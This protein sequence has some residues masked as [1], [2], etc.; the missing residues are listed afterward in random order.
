MNNETEKLELM[1]NMK[2]DQESICKL[3]EE[4]ESTA[5]RIIEAR[6]KNEPFHDGSP[7]ESD[8]M[9]PYCFEKVRVS[10]TIDRGYLN[11]NG[12]VEDYIDSVRDLFVECV[13]CGAEFNTDYIDF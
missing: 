2:V 7:F 13:E 12:L 11:V 5:V 1:K 10:G 4:Y 6:V 8:M 9:C 3:I